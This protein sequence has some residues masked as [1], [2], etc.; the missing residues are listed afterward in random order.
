MLGLEGPAFGQSFAAV[1]SWPPGAAYC[2]AM[3]RPI[4]L[5]LLVLALPPA[6]AQDRRNVFDDP[7]QQL[8]HG[9]AGCPMPAGPLLTRDEAIAEA[10]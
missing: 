5:L 6:S 7:F 1:H 9:Q 10:H 2:R 4:I 3:D 8:T